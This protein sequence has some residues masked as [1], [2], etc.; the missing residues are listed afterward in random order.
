MT[1]SGPS[2]SMPCVFPFQFKGIDHNQC[3]WDGDSENGPWCSTNV[4]DDGKH[5]S[6][7][8]NWGNC[9]SECP[10]SP[11]PYE[12]KS[13]KTITDESST[14]H[15]QTTDVND[16]N[17]DGGCFEEN[18]KY[19]P[20][21]IFGQGRSV[22]Y[23]AR[24]CQS[25]C[26]RFEGCSYFSF[27]P[28]DGGC[29]LSR[30]SAKMVADSIAVSGPKRCPKDKLDY[31]GHGC[32]II[33][34]GGGED[35]GKPCIFPFSY[36]GIEY[37]ECTTI[38]NDRKHWCA[39]KVDTNGSYIDGKWGNCN[40][41]CPKSTQDQEYLCGNRHCLWENYKEGIDWGF[42][43]ESNND[44]KICQSNCTNDENCVGVECGGNIHYCSW[45]KRGRCVSESEQTMNHDEHLTCTKADGRCYSTAHII[46]GLPFHNSILLL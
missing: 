6:G 46:S 3:I 42:Y 35:P 36:K 16:K 15:G 30:S 24:A 26:A 9:A 21:D 4:D 37:T 22:E 29:H 23:D 19:I 38:D 32:V 11:S 44:C 2:P 41:I 1:I 13:Q 20:L 28:H 40:S 43:S 14:K 34:G 17:V 7:E 18:S 10:F 25:R 31:K 33:G 8:G 27:W 45:W 39:T 5:I 12:D